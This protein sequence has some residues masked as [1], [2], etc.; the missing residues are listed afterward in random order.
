MEFG[1][2]VMTEED[3]L[4]NK[5]QSFLNYTKKNQSLK[6]A[7]YHFLESDCLSDFHNSDTVEQDLVD[8]FKMS[9]ENWVKYEILIPNLNIALSLNEDISS[10]IIKIEKQIN[11]RNSRHR[12]L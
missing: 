1:Y 11:H 10:T 5:L 7:G 12:Q 3:L 6:I 4:V 8:L 2:D 9:E